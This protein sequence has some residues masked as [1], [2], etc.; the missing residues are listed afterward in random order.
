[1]RRE[2]PSGRAIQLGIERHLRERSTGLVRRV[3]A[4]HR[5]REQPCQP[6][7]QPIPD[8]AE[9]RGIVAGQTRA[10]DEAGLERVHGNPTSLPRETG[11]LDPPDQLVSEPQVAELAVDVC[12]AAVERPGA[13]AAGGGERRQICHGGLR[14]PGPELRVVHAGRHDDDACGRVPHET[15]EEQIGEQ[16]VAEVVH[17][18]RQ[19]VTVWGQ[20]RSFVHLEPRVADERTQ[21]DVPGVDLADELAH[22]GGGAEVEAQLGGRIRAAVARDPVH[23]LRRCL[24]VPACDEHVP[25][26][27]CELPRAFEADARVP[28]GHEYDVAR[29]RIS[30]PAPTQ[31]TAL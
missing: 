16:E 5:R 13:G 31:S 21:W 8:E 17:R 12:E 9:H 19:L 23:G 10:G 6:R 26:R 27:A 1:M 24:A 2:V 29:H 11:G 15:R 30:P 22:R 3:D 18:E 4:G 20:Q 25:S 28:A 7:Q 14:H